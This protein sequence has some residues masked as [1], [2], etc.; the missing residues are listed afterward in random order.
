M[1]IADFNKQYYV[2]VS[3]LVRAIARKKEV[4]K[5]LRQEEEISPWW[6]WAYW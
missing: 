2:G 3:E 1:S 5:G 6:V 4:K